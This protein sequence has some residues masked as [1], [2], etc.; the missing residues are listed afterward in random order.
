[1]KGVLKHK[2]TVHEVHNIQHSVLETSRPTQPFAQML[3]L[4]ESL[5][6]HAP[7]AKRRPQPTHQ[8]SHTH[9]VSNGLKTTATRIVHEA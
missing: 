8:H 9:Q 7:I 3:R 2:K 1:M 4:N 6:R 5:G